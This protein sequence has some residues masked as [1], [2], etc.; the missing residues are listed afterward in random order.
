MKKAILF[1]MFIAI[2][3]TV[4]CAKKA[5]KN[6]PY[7]E[8]KMHPIDRTGVQKFLGTNR[9]DVLDECSFFAKNIVGKMKVKKGNFIY[10]RGTDVAGFRG[11]YDTT[12]YAVQMA[13]EARETCIAAIE[14]YLSDFENKALDRNLKAQKSRRLYG[15]TIIYIDFGVALE[16]MNYKAKPN[17][18][19]GYVFDNNSPYFVIH[20][21]KAKN[22]TLEG[23]S[24]QDYGNL[25]TVVVNFYFTRK[26]A[27]ALK[28][29]IQNDNI[30]ALATKYDYKE[31]EVDAQNEGAEYFE[32][33]DA[34]P[35]K[36]SRSKK[37]KDAKQPQEGDD[38][39][40]EDPAEADGYT[41]IKM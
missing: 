9:Y 1:S 3:L 20:L 12:S 31:I 33:D 28:E 7:D 2:A 22:L 17:A 11:Y 6:D 24:S 23:K 10:R 25:E 36:K 14:K 18:T 26:Q 29:F 32:A 34:V 41:E 21:D 15:E 19:F 27:Q 35:E 5:K 40:E 8:K 39:S 16:M 13:Q 38:Y 30:N 4:A 37:S